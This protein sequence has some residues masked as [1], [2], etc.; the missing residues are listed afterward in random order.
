MKS[1]KKRNKPR[2]M[3]HGG[4]KGSLPVFFPL[5]PVASLLHAA[6]VSAPGRPAGENAPY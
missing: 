2:R 1:K 3:S 5:F 6:L 4:K